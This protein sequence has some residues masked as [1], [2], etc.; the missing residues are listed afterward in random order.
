M[1][2]LPA[3]LLIEV[4]ARL[5]DGASIA[6]ACMVRKEMTGFINDENLWLAH[7]QRHGPRQLLAHVAEAGD[8]AI[9]AALRAL[10][11][12]RAIPEATA[13]AA[14]ADDAISPL[15]VPLARILRAPNRPSDAMIKRLV[16]LAFSS[17]ASIGRRESTRAL[18][19]AYA[20]KD[21][22]GVLDL[23]FSDARVAALAAAPDVN[24]VY[25]A[26]K[27]GDEAFAEFILVRHRAICQTSPSWMLRGAN[28]F[29]PL[30]RTSWSSHPL[31]LRVVKLIVDLTTNPNDLLHA[32]FYL[33]FKGRAAHLRIVLDELRARFE[34]G[35]DLAHLLN[36]RQFAYGVSRSVFGAVLFWRCH[37]FL[38]GTPG[39]DA[40]VASCLRM[41]V[42]AGAIVR[43]G[44][45]TKAVAM[46]SFTEGSEAGRFLRS[47]QVPG[48]WCHVLE[49]PFAL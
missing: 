22:E 18:R 30:V 39:A 4:L 41:L 42:D 38:C 24:P 33:T 7:A 37:P 8:G 31:S 16:D 36:G 20:T 17:S 15:E 45:L 34:D 43:E 10:E 13:L 40:G 11:R 23:L 2:A 44:A 25:E 19:D 14:S 1:D 48:R 6:R 26:C 9:R 29:T 27:S 12:C 5:P 35:D 28:D 3:D 32:V 46:Q 49:P 47:V 21:A